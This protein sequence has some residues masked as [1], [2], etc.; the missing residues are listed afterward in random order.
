MPGITPD[1]GSVLA[2]AATICFEG[3]HHVSGVCLLVEG[4]FHHGFVVEWSTLSNPEQAIRAWADVQVTTEHG[5]CGV[6]ALLVTKLTEFT[7]AARSWKGTGFDYWLSRKEE[8][9]NEDGL[10]QG[11]ARLEVSG[12]RHGNGTV[13]AA[14]IRNKIDQIERAP[15]TGLPAIIAVIEFGKPRSHLLKRI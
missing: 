6:A 1:I 2:Q 12:I 15:R 7:I 11:K 9:G 3:E 14:R 4:D 13:V 8:A 10:F 5:A